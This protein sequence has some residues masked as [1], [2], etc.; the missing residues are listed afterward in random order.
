ME[1]Q[2]VLDPG[3]TVCLGLVWSGF[4]Q[5]VRILRVDMVKQIT[6]IKDL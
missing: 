6:P 1:W 4:I 5:S 2:T 3:H